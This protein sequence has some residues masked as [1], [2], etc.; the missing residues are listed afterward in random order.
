MTD[1]RLWR[2]SSRSSVPF[3]RWDSG[4]VVYNPFSGNTHFLDDVTGELC[5]AIANGV[6][7]E[8]ELFE[9]TRSRVDA[10]DDEAASED[11]HRRLSILYE[12]GLIEPAEPC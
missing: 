1:A 12:V 7:A 3:R 8:P 4:V 11:F 6:S 5:L 2:T 9:F 10:A